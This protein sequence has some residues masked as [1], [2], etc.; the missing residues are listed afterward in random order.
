MQSSTMR[1]GPVRRAA[2]PC[3][4]RV[5]KARL[6]PVRF[7]PDVREAEV[8]MRRQLKGP[9]VV[10]LVGLRLASVNVAR[11][12]H[13]AANLQEYMTH[14]AEHFS[15]IPLPLGGKLSR[16]DA[17]HIELVVPKIEIFDI[18][19]QPKAVTQVV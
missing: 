19:L 2:L 14:A 12:A 9:C 1:Q 8:V 16:L 10:E 7:Q 3:H 6:Q 17:T 15:N 18:W 11:H 5:S 4:Q 13:P